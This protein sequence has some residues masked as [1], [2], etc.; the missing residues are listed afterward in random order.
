[1][2]V[3]F[4]LSWYSQKYSSEAGLS[5]ASTNLGERSAEVGVGVHEQ[6]HNFREELPRP[7]PIA[8]SDTTLVN[9]RYVPRGIGPWDGCSSM[10]LGGGIFF[11]RVPGLFPGL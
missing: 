2:T 3:P 9:T 1:M 6:S 8:S 7:C 4:I 11:Y 10:D 5:S